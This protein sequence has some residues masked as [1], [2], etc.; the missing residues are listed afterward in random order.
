MRYTLHNS[1]NLEHFAQCGERSK[2]HNEPRATN[3]VQDKYSDKL[4]RSFQL[5]VESNVVFGFTLIRSLNGSNRHFLNH[6][7]KTKINRS[8]QNSL[9]VIGLLLLWFW[10][11]DTH[12]KTALYCLVGH[13]TGKSEQIATRGKT[14]LHGFCVNPENASPPDIKNRFSEYRD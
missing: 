5:S 1:L 3:K 6:R 2:L 10:R 7:G 4:N 13:S 14:E 9:F 11:Y 8:F 12:F